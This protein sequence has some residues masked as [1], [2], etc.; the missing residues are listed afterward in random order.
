VRA[1]NLFLLLAMITLPVSIA[2]ATQPTN[3]QTYNE[4]AKPT[5]TKL[6]FSSATSMAAWELTGLTAGITYLGIQSW[7]WGSSSF[8]MNSEGWFG[9]DTGSGGADKLGHLYTTYLM[10]EWLTYSLEQSTHQPKESALYGSLFGWGLF[11]YI[12][13][14]DGYSNDHGFST[15][16][17]VMNSIG[18]GFSYL[19]STQP[20]LQDKIDLRVEYLPSPGMKGVH[21]MTDYSGYKYLAVV[22]PAGFKSVKNSFLKY[23]EF[24]LGYYTRGFKKED[25]PYFDQRESTLYTAISINLSELIFKNID[26]KYH[27]TAQP[28]DSFFQYYQVPGIYAAQNI[29]QQQAGLR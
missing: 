20:W 23:F 8:N 2:H 14:F 29:S 1:L 10:S 6:N 9:M 27:N 3:K 5:L 22:K 24:H 28:I 4:S 15:E 7:D 16:D 25:T 17:L 11:L 26:P 19:K 12:E 18:A 21:P 13:I